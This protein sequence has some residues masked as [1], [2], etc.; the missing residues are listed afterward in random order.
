M[1]WP[2][3]SEPRARR[4]VIDL[5]LRIRFLVQRD[6]GLRNV[7]HRNDIDPVGRAKRQNRQA[8][9][10]YECADHVELRRFRAAAVAQHDARTKHGSRNIGQQFPHHVLAEFFR[11]RI[12]IVVGAVPVDGS[13]FGNHFVAAVPRHGDGGNLAEA[14]QAV[15]VLRAASELRDFQSAAQIHVEAAFFGFAIERCRAMNHRLGRADQARVV[16]G[17]Q[18]ETR[19]GK[20]SAKNGNARFECV[21]ELRKIQMQLQRVPEALVG[22]LLRLRAH[23]QVQAVRVALQQKGGDVRADVAG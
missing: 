7:V 3:V 1:S 6:D 12:G 4:E 20:I 5:V 14:A 16:G 11:A 10:K 15:R 19:L 8:R 18:P 13:V 23:Q 17:V 9:K 2:N 21:L 22:L